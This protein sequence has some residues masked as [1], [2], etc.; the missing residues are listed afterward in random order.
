[1]RKHTA[2]KAGGDTT[3]RGDIRTQPFD[4]SPA[5]LRPVER[6]RICDS[7][8]SEDC[9]RAVECPARRRPACRPS[10]PAPR[11]PQGT[12]APP[13][14]ARDPAGPSGARAQ[15]AA[16]T[17]TVLGLLAE[18]NWR[19]VKIGRGTSQGCRS[20]WVR[21]LVTFCLQYKPRFSPNIHCVAL[22]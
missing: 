13:T 10:Q 17:P 20:T 18:L 11:D 8:V 1:M 5:Y 19:V 15:C 3:R 7:L 12:P 14:N 2:M 21:A 16:Y 4:L 22:V 6:R 9:D